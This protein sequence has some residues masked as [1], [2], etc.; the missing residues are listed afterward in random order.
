MVF[1][2]S[3]KRLRKPKQSP[4]KP[5][6]GRLGRAR[7][8]L[9]S[10]GSG[11]REK[12]KLPVV[13]MPSVRGR[14]PSVP[15]VQVKRPSRPSRPELD[16]GAI[17][18]PFEDLAWFLRKRAIWPLAD[19]FS[20]L[21]TR[22]RIATAGG[23]ALAAGIGVAALA[24]AVSGGA[25]SSAPA[26]SAPVA[27]V[28]PTPAPASRPAIKV[29][30][31][32]RKTPPAPTLHGPAPVFAA[33][34]SKA[35]PGAA[36]AAAAEPSSATA[37]AQPKKVAKPA[38][39]ATK[40]ANV[41]AATAKIGATPSASATASSDD[42]APGAAASTEGVASNSATGG[43]TRLDGPPAGPKAIK[44]ARSFAG[45][46]VVYET[47]GIDATVRRTFGNSATPA[48]SHSLLKRPPRLPAQ[49]K[50]PRAKVVNIVPGPSQGKV[51]TVSVS[52]LRVGVTSELRLE[53]EQRKRDGWQ[54]TN[55]LG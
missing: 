34:K 45:A 37:A 47:G 54:V 50:V 1:P 46:F 41:P 55:V 51:F 43:A 27:V 10:A 23:V 14:R 40:P 35:K 36:K 30:A 6:P 25:G 19:R 49:V 17:R 42:A 31:P 22:G 7:A 2:H 9:A 39:E 21:G 48:L 12:A 38:E 20:G 29:V 44:V 13:S 26:A 52:L 8:A 16:L 15:S 11:L 4:I 5:D 33:P 28:A 3:L 32:K 18:S 24:L 53:M